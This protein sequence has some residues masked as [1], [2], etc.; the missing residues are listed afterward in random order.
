MG[1]NWSVET[2]VKQTVNIRWSHEFLNFW[3]KAASA[4]T[5]GNH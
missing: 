4:R 2:N 5:L 1:E 3:N